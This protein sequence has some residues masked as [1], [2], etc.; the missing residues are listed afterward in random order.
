MLS[1]SLLESHAILKGGP[2]EGLE[3][4]HSRTS[5][6][7]RRGSGASNATTLS[8]CNLLYRSVCPSAHGRERKS[9][10][11]G[12]R[13]HTSG[14]A[15]KRGRPEGSGCRVPGLERQVAA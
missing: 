11:A 15:V 7:S 13:L 5:A 3:R 4:A 2:A 12:R 8:T 6:S 10:L 1:K 14:V 9:G